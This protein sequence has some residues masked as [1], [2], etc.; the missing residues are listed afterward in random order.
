MPPPMM[1]RIRRVAAGAAGLGIGEGSASSATGGSLVRAD[2]RAGAT[3]AGPAAR[4]RRAQDGADLVLHRAAVAR[5]AQPQ[6]LFE[7][8]VELADGDAGHGWASLAGSPP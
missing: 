1:S 5:G 7:A 4:C 8:F 2:R 3:S 6:L